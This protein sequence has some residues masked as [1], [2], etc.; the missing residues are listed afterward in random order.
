MRN[1]P[2]AASL[3]VSLLAISCATAGN[4]VQDGV[5]ETIRAATN[6]TVRFELTKTPGVPPGIRLND[7]LSRDEAVATAL[8]NSAAFQV[9][10]SRLGFARADLADAGIIG[11]PVLSLLFPV[12]P[13][14]LEATL[15]W[16]VEFLW[17][18]PRRVSAAKLS[19]E[20]AAK[21]LVQSGLDLALSVKLAYADLALATDRQSL[22][23]EAAAANER[24]DALTQSRL[25]AGDVAELDARTARVD[26]V[27][28]A[29]DADRAVHDV[30]I[31]RER[32]RLLMGLAADDRAIDRLQAPGEAERCGLEGDLLKRALAARPDLRAAELAIEAAAARLG[33]EDSRVVALTALLDANGAG[34]EGFEIG[35][36]LD[37]GIPLFN[38]TQG[39]RLRAGAELQRAS[40]AYVLL[41]Q[42]VVLDVREAS[43]QL[44]QAR[45]SRRVWSDEIVTPL[46]AN[47]TD[48][49]EAYAAGDRSFLFV[50]ENSRRLI[51]ARTRERE[52]AAEEQRARARIERAAGIACRP[53]GGGSR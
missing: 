47:L 13:K 45:Q 39:S 3:L 12:G 31:A 20:V 44:E 21:G 50:L 2:A 42:Q 22:A 41:Q 29:Q 37:V 1:R 43:A 27:R 36:G 14:Q 26:A 48:A 49:E 28:S 7:G 19:L 25:A 11:N 4:S 40:A 35:P 52:I 34:K 17:E 53:A 8:W 10:V 23:T 33:W 15:R 18:R 16:P 6:A 46:G 32:L 5:A 51:E 30:T 9:S 24:I 38:R